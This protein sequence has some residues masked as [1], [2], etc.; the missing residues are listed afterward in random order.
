M[1]ITA[2]TIHQTATDTESGTVGDSIPRTL[3]TGDPS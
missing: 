2:D 1:T 3:Q